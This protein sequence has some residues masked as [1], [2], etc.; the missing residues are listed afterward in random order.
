MRVVFTG[1]RSW[2]DG[3]QVFDVLQD[4]LRD[5]G[6]GLVIAHGQS[7]GGGADLLV[8]QYAKQ[9]GIDQKPYPVDR[10]L[11]GNHRGAPLNRNTRMLDDFRPDLVIAFRA[12]GK[13][14][15]TDDTIRK[16]EK[17]NIPVRKVTQ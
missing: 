7:S 5:Y 9:L 16:A 17:R 11:D 12:P 10:E 2:V 4:L 15:G 13:S 6:Q 1:S 3:D 14:N 8:A